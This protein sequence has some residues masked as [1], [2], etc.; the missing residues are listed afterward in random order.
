MSKLFDILEIFNEIEFTSECINICETTIS[1]ATRAL[2]R[3]AGSAELNAILQSATDDK[4]RLGD[5]FTA[6][7]EKFNKLIEQ[8]KSDPEF[9]QEIEKTTIVPER[10]KKAFLAIKAELTSTSKGYE[11]PEE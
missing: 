9:I 2:K 6:L 10:L 8:A 1:D 7:K 4:K 11:K 5:K 3:D